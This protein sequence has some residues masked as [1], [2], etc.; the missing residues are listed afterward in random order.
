MPAG[1]ARAP[2]ADM[3]R[4]HGA[5]AEADEHEPVGGEAVARQLGVE[6][7]VERPA[8]PPPRRA[9]IRWDRAS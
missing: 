9:S 8:V 3:Q 1:A 5:L 4:H 2:Q 7:A 6:K